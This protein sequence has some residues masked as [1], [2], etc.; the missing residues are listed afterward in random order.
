MRD[1]L[2]HLDVGPNAAYISQVRA[3]E[4]IKQ[5]YGFENYKEYLRVLLKT[6]LWFLLKHALKF[7]FMDEHLHGQILMKHYAKSLYMN[8]GVGCDLLTL[9]PRNHCKTTFGSG[10][11]IQEILNN[12][13][14]AIAIVSGTEKLAK[15]ISKVIADS[16]TDNAVLQEAFPD[17]LPTKENPAKNWGIR[18]YYL[19]T[20]TTARVDPTLVVGSVTANVTGT[21]P[22]ILFF[23]DIVY[24]K[25]ESDLE[26]SELCFIEAMGLMSSTGKVFINGT[27]W[28]DR[29]LYGKIIE[30]TLSGNLGSYEQL[31]MSCWEDD[32]KSIPTYPKKA[33]GDDAVKMTGFSREDLARK[34]ANNPEFFN[35]QYLNDPAPEEEQLMKVDDIQ[36]YE[37]SQTP[38]YTRAMG[39]GV[40]I[41]GTSVTF[42]S[43]FRRVCDDFSCNIFLQEI[44]PKRSQGSASK[45]NKEDRILH[46]LFPIVNEK[47]LYAQKWMIEEKRGLA[48]EVRRFGAAKND[49]IVD[50]LHM[51][52]MYMSMGMI[53]GSNKPANCYISADLAFTKSEDA[54]WTVFLALAIDFKGRHFILD[55]KRFQENDPLV[56]AREL[57]KFYQKINSKAMD[58]MY[59]N[60]KRG[61]RLALSYQ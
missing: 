25:S 40:E 16:L 50:A 56:I 52:P 7:N 24:A 20:R 18:G 14:I 30:G 23:D 61:S 49:D 54:D 31:I 5:D 60:K 32:N 4:Q 48:Y 43:V 2:I 59:Y 44:T 57:I 58:S 53:P 1:F 26:R 36:L 21:H 19:P 27:R 37:E 34:R 12:V 35:C 47:L 55:Y 15:F 13:D 8:R 28:S 22:D 11:L 45:K 10:F 3:L 33:R 9:L 41:V 38:V 6:D 17:L 46:T 39:V 51:V 29:D 42:P